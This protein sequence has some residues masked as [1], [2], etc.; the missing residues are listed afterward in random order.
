MCNDKT[1]ETPEATTEAAAGLTVSELKEQY[2]DNY[3]RAYETWR[4]G[5]YDIDYMLEDSLSFITDAAPAG[6]K[7]AAEAIRYEIDDWYTHASWSGHIDMR[8]YIAAHPDLKGGTEESMESGMLWSVAETLIDNNLITPYVD[9]LDRYSK[10]SGYRSAYVIDVD[11]EENNGRLRQELDNYISIVEDE[12]DMDSI[13]AE[14]QCDAQARV[15]EDPVWRIKGGMFDGLRVINLLQLVSPSGMGTHGADAIETLLLDEAKKVAVAY[16]DQI[17]E[18]LRAEYEYLLSEESFEDM[19]E[20]NG[21][22]F[23]IEGETIYD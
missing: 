16:Q 19:H 17:K 4:A 8:D 9:V 7:V 18:S 20:C 14:S 22:L 2:S 21:W 1:T 5:Q 15:L 23:T 11:M 13:Y 10:H 6:V 12:I 3:N